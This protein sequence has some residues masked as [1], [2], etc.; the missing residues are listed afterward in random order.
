MIGAKI[1]I[2]AFNGGM[3][4]LERVQKSLGLL[5]VTKR[6]DVRLSKIGNEAYEGL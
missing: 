1:G 2:L 3:T 4:E 6:F 5:Q